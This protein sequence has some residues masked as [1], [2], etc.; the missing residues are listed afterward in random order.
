M[1]I[2]RPVAGKHG[3]EVL[4]ISLVI[5]H[6]PYDRAL[7]LHQL[8]VARIIHYPPWVPTSLSQT[9][10]ISF[11]ALKESKTTPAISRPGIVVGVGPSVEEEG[12]R[13]NERKIS[14]YGDLQ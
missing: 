6:I 9:W 5:L 7:H 12:R 3:I 2:F 1:P 8:F 10:I 4:E 13:N 14:C 11:A